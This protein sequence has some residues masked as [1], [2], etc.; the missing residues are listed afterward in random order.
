MVVQAMNWCSLKY[1]YAKP[2]TLRIPHYLIEWS[3]TSV[4]AE[5]ELFLILY[6][7]LGL[8]QQPVATCSKVRNGRPV[9]DQ[10]LES[11]NESFA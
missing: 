5:R 6:G 11:W 2:A 1:T 4:E 10:D 8:H 7:V 9:V 3:C